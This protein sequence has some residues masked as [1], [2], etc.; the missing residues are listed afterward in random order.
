MQEAS[1]LGMSVLM[2]LY[3][4][5]KEDAFIKAFE[6]I[7]VNQTRLPDEVVLVQDGPLSFDL[8]ILKLRSYGVAVN[9]LVLEKNMGIVTAL[10]KGLS[11]VQGEIV[12][13]M[14]SDDIAMPSRLE[15]T[16]SKFIS[17]D[18]VDLFCGSI[19]EIDSISNKKK[20]RRAN[21]FPLSKYMIRN[22]F[23]HPAVSFKKSSVV[24]V[25]G[26]RQY[27]GFE[28]FDLWL[29]L[30]DANCRFLTSDE[31]VLQFNV[32]EEFFLRRSGFS[33]LIKELAFLR[34]VVKENLY[35]IN[36]TSNFLIRVILR[37]APKPLLKLLYRYRN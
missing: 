25:G 14:D 33:Y 6:S 7:T 24:A 3:F 8:D 26:Y 27:G 16:E 12:V 30:Y 32:T 23:F 5:D 1:S 2:P 34:I 15:L 35:D 18:N 22:P 36:Y 17:N 10:N 20:L 19:V 4:G 13:R 37:L 21:C 9:H 31:I 11:V 28:D 29:R